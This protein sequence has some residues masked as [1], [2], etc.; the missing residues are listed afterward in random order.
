MTIRIRIAEPGDDGLFRAPL[1]GVFDNPV[2]PESLRAFLDDPGHHIALALEGDVVVGV[3]SANE[4]LHPDKP[5]QVWINEI[6][7]APGRRG[8]GIGRALLDAMLDHLKGRGFAKVWL[9]TEHDNAPAR[10][11]FRAAGGRETEGVVMYEFG[12]E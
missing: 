1:P 11:L 5:G 6:G 10:A 8:E 12:A 4:Y 7:V 9:A 3:V 2:R